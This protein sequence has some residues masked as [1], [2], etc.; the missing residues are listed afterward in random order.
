MG[1][2]S[3]HC[4]YTKPQ[5]IATKVYLG[6]FIPSLFRMKTAFFLFVLAENMEK[7]QQARLYE[8]CYNLYCQIVDTQ[9]DYPA[10]WDK[11]L[12]LAAERLLRSGGRGHGLDS[13]LS[14]SIRHFS[15]Y[16][17]REPTDP[18]SKAIRSIITHLKKEHEKLR[19][20]QKA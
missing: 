1:Y 11:N 19:D 8:L 12:A 9:V 17:Q 18:Q 15:H 14:R 13:L 6:A 4:I 5:Y 7:E 16:L 2:G 10:N 20:R 3:H